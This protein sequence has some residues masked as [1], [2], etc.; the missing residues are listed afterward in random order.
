[1]R[2][3]ALAHE[4]AHFI[5]GDHNSKMLFG[6][7]SRPA[8]EPRFQ[9]P[10]KSY[11]RYE[12]RRMERI[13]DRVG[14]AL[15]MNPRTFRD[16]VRQDDL[17]GLARRYQVGLRD[18]MD[19]A[20]TLDVCPMGRL[21]GFFDREHRR[22]HEFYTLLSPSAPLP[23]V[24][25]LYAFSASM[26]DLGAVIEQWM[27]SPSRRHSARF[28]VGDSEISVAVYSHERARRLMLLFG[29]AEVV[30]ARRLDRGL[31]RPFTRIDG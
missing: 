28:A 30:R 3:S 8:M 2:R 12:Q 26:N 14:H 22:I 6:H 10:S 5:N 11:V 7:V 4:L 15:L 21:V 16:H 17:Y 31:F 19:F 25:A 13:A 27:E 29:Q 18:A 20:V 23:I 9:S 1:L 24:H